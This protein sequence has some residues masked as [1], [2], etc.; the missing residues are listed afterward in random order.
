MRSRFTFEFWLERARPL[1]DLTEV[2][3]EFATVTLNALGLP[4]TLGVMWFAKQIAE[5]GA[6]GVPPILTFR[7]V[8]WIE[9]RPTNDHLWVS[10]R[11]GDSVA[12]VAP[13]V[14]V[15]C[16]GVEPKAITIELSD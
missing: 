6:G 1:T 9:Y 8:G 4:T 14:K 15:F 13:I 12:S 5:Q 11:D 7:D 2:E 3:L 16:E 10:L